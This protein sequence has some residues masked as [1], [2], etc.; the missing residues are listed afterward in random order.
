MGAKYLPEL[1]KLLEGFYAAA[2]KVKDEIAATPEEDRTWQTY[3]VAYELE[4]VK[5]LL[6]SRVGK[7]MV[8]DELGI[9]SKVVEPAFMAAKEALFGFYAEHSAEWSADDIRGLFEREPVAAGPIEKKTLHLVAEATAIEGGDDNKFPFLIVA[10]GLSKNRKNYG[11]EALRAGASLFNDAP[12]YLDHPDG[13]HEGRPQPRKFE[14]KVGWWSDA[15]FAEASKKHPAGIVATANIMSSSAH[16]WLSGMIKEAVESGKPDLIGVSIYVDIEAQPVRDDTHGVVYNVIKLTNVRSADLVAEPAA[17]GRALVAAESLMEVDPEM[18]DEKTTLKISDLTDDQLRDELLPRLK[19]LG[20]NVAEQIEPTPPPAPKPDEK[21]FE[22]PAAVA[23]KLAAAEAAFATIEETAKRLTDREKKIAARESGESLA[24]A[25][26]AAKLPQGVI[27]IAVGEAEGLILDDD[28]IA[29]IIERYKSVVAEGYDEVRRQLPPTQRAMFNINPL[30][31]QVNPVERALNAL[32][33]FFGNEV[34][35]DIKSNT[36]K[37][38]SFRQFYGQMTGDWDVSG[39][40]NK[41]E[42]V[43]GDWI[44]MSAAEAIPTQAKF[45]GGATVT[46]GNLFGVSM[47]RRLLG[48]YRGQNR[49]WEPI[50]VQGPLSNFKQQDRIRT[51]NYGPLTNRPVGTEEYTELTWGETVETYVPSGWGNIVS[52]NRRAIINDD[53]NGIRRQPVLLARAATVTINEYVS[54]LFT[55]NAGAG[56]TMT[57]TNPAFHA[58]R[59]NTGA[60]ALTYANL[61]TVRSAFL[62]LADSAGNKLLNQLRY[63]IVPVDLS[64]PAWIFINSDGV[65]GSNNNDPNLFADSE[66]GIRGIITVPNFT[67]ATNWYA[68]V[69]PEEALMVPVEVGFINDQREPELFIQD[70]PTEGMVFT[71]DGMY[72]K[73]RFE[74]GADI[75]DANAMYGSIVAG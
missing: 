73:V 52:V 55:A 26:R 48:V 23:E 38:T 8:K 53:L 3:D 21:V 20:L 60:L 4:D 71:N 27:A 74:F 15:T 11:A 62:K 61:L 69:D 45:V 41:G 10:S 64:D 6:I 75:I 40:Y 42:A 16:P 34:A 47:N 31:R 36:P 28:A 43:L 57:D 22:L 33:V 67:D 49:W 17:G 35:E 7:E 51:N 72:F 25:M 18:G 46:M 29:A 58:S 44:G 13:V 39:M 32:D 70:G 2:N 66:R 68:S 5:R 14:D 37:I 54:G 59:G 56:V 65:P 12:I 30:D 24:V 1:K 50:S 19:A 9:E 63:L